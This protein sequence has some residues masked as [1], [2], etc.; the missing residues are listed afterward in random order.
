MPASGAKTENG[1]SALAVTALSRYLHDNGMETAYDKADFG[2][3]G[4]C[5][6]VV[7]AVG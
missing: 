1:L 7:L 3:D 5:C 6:L 4:A 2:T